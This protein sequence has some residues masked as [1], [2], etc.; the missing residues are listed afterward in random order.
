MPYLGIF[1]L[2]FKKT[3]VLFEICTVKFLNLQSF[4][5]KQKGVNSEPKMPSFGIF[6]QEF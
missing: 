5:R 4:A 2:E 1:G 3:F 6:S